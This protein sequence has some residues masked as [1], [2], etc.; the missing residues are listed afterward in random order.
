MSYAFKMTLPDL[1]KKKSFLQKMHLSLL[2]LL[3]VFWSYHA[4]MT[5]GIDSDFNLVINAIGYITVG[6]SGFFILVK[7]LMGNDNLFIQLYQRALNRFSF[8]ITSN[9]LLI[10]AVVVLIFQVILYGVIEIQIP[11]RLASEPLQLVVMNIDE[12]GKDSFEIVDNREPYRIK[13]RAGQYLFSL[14]DLRTKQILSADPFTSRFFLLKQ[15]VITN[16]GRLRN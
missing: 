1:A 16:D 6:L 7:L 12:K 4:F 3:I 11:D 15:K 10:S 13:L 14:K 8:L 5:S 9:T 2:F